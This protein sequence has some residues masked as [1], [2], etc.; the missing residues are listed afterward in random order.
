MCLRTVELRIERRAESPGSH[1]A[2]LF[3][4]KGGA[5]NVVYRNGLTTE[6]LLRWEQVRQ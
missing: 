1:E 3:L 5:K 4:W 2:G 6:D